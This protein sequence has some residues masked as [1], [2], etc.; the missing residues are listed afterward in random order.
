MGC[1]NSVGENE[2]GDRN[3]GVC[4]YVPTDD[5]ERAVKERFCLDVESCLDRFGGS[6]RLV[7]LGDMNAKVGSERVE[8]VVGPWE[9]HWWTFMQREGC[10]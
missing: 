1:K 10:W 4:T 8:G 5:R 3:L 2:G 9:V 6:E 7:M